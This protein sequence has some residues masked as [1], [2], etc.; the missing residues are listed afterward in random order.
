MRW[1]LAKAARASKQRPYNAPDAGVDGGALVVGEDEACCLSF[2]LLN[3]GVPAFF[4]TCCSG[5][6]KPH[7][8]SGRPARV[9]GIQA[10]IDSLMDRRQDSEVLEVG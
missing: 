3:L 10:K 2:L 4:K 8:N 6:I 7:M 1:Y 9:S 5:A